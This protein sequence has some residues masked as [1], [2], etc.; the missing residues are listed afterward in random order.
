MSV[1]RTLCESV[2]E[3]RASGMSGAI[4]HGRA[5]AVDA[6]ISVDTAGTILAALNEERDAGG[7]ALRVALAEVIDVIGGSASPA[8][9][10]EFLCRAPEE[11]RL[12]ME[13]LEQRYLHAADK[14]LAAL[15]REKAALDQ[16]EALRAVVADKDAEI[17]RLND[18]IGEMSE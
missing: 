14:N 13:R 16:V 17:K 3:A 9:S 15:R 5:C 7:I 6:E 11:T 18:V 10:V 4:I 12:V 8:A 2:L 1:L